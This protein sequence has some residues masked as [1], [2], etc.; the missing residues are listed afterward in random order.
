[1]V[2][3]GVTTGMYFLEASYYYNFLLN[4][5]YKMLQYYYDCMNNVEILCLFNTIDVST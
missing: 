4:I 1:M 2:V 3:S 5:I